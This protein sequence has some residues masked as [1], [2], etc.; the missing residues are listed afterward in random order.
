MFSAIKDNSGPR[1]ECLLPSSRLATFPQHYTPERHMCVARVW[2]V[3]GVRTQVLM[4]SHT[5]SSY[6]MDTG[7]MRVLG[8][9]KGM[10]KLLYVSSELNY[11]HNLRGE[12]ALDRQLST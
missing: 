6:C 11:E 12:C 1:Q 9:S 2:E 7:F 8:F 3:L 4:F 5:K 10:L